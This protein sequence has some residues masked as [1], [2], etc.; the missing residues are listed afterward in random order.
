LKLELTET[1]VID[2]ME[3]S[4]AKMSELRSAGV[5]FS[6]DDFGTGQSSLSY[7]TRLPLSQ[8]KIDQSLCA[9]WVSAIP[10]MWWPR[11]SSA[12]PTTWPDGDCRRRGAAVAFR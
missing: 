5:R 6:M 7:L 8:L 2:D 12:W 9:T 11:P 4:I 1:L 3:D 10:T